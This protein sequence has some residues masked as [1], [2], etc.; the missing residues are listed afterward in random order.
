MLTSTVFASPPHLN[1]LEFRA[2]PAVSQSR[3]TSLPVLQE[4]DGPQRHE[5]AQKHGSSIIE[6][7]ASLQTQTES[8]STD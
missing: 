3:T 1:V 6:Q 7:E 5:D 2:V 4:G 8:E